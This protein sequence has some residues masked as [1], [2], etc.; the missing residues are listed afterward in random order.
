MARQKQK[1]QQ[2][3]RFSQWLS[4]KLA[5]WMLTEKPRHDFPICDFKRICYEIRPC[6]VLLVE[7]HS[8]MSRAVN[9]ITHS[10]WSHAM[11]YI[12]K[13]NNIENETLRQH[14]AEH[15]TGDPEALLII[16]SFLGKGTIVRSLAHYKGSHLRICRPKGI[17]PTD[18]H[19]VIEYCINALGGD[20]NV[21]QILGMMSLL[22]PSGARIR[23]FLL[24]LFGTQ[25]SRKNRRK[26]C[27]SLLAEAFHSVE[28]PTLPKII[29]NDSKEIEL[30]PRNPSLFTPGDFDYS[31]YFEIIKYPLFGMTDVAIYRKFPWNKEIFSND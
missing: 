15:Y 2:K 21:W 19:K 20:Y 9:V 7:G 16:E 10:P 26:V 29:L 13:L 28:F 4:I 5:N 3:R 11:L 6:D 17:A 8:R 23:Q 31:P 18:A 24:S 25:Q 14:V 12:G 22:L 1:S 27:S 30:V